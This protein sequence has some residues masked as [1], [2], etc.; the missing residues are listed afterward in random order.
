MSIFFRNK[1]VGRGFLSRSDCIETANREVKSSYLK[2]MQA[3][4]AVPSYKR[5]QEHLKEPTSRGHD[6]T[7][8]ITRIKNDLQSIFAKNTACEIDTL[9]LLRVLRNLCINSRFNQDQLLKMEIPCY[10][11]KLLIDDV[12]GLS[13]DVKTVGLQFI[14]NMLP[15]N[16]AACKDL[17]PALY[18][19]LLEYFL[20]TSAFSDKHFTICSMILYNC[21]ID[22]PL[23]GCLFRNQLGENLIVALCNHIDKVSDHD[24]IVMLIKHQFFKVN[25]F[26]SLVVSKCSIAAITET[27]QLLRGVFDEVINSVDSL[28]IDNDFLVLYLCE[29]FS[30][31]YSVCKENPSKD[32]ADLIV[33]IIEVLCRATAFPG[34]W[35]KNKVVTKVMDDTIELLQDINLQKGSINETSSRFQLYG[36]LQRQLVKR[37]VIRL[38]GNICFENEIVQNRIR[39]NGGIPLI[40]QCCTID[41]DNPLIQQWAIFAMRNLCRNNLENQAEVAKFERVGIADSPVLKSMGLTVVENEEGKMKVERINE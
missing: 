24:W 16:Q 41:D 10:V 28:N 8:L 38:I 26:F 22:M 2:N 37:S 27:F 13:A 39:T 15:G 34:H 1:T 6:Y 23:V 18:P 36:Y 35:N 32:V 21:L 19:D 4:T 12:V 31:R 20:V 29:V 25:E 7:E 11:V 9:N 33:S 40:L 30:E 14:G 17:W 3:F 5:L